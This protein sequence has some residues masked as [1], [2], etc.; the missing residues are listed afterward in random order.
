MHTTV[1]QSL[2]IKLF[3]RRLY[4]L[5][6]FPSWTEGKTSPNSEDR[7]LWTARWGICSTHS[8]VLLYLQH[9]SP[10]QCPMWVTVRLMSRGGWQT[11]GSVLTARLG[12]VRPAT[13]LMEAW[14]ER[15]NTRGETHRGQTP[16]GRQNQGQEVQWDVRMM[17]FRWKYA[18]WVSA[19]WTDILV[20]RVMPYW[21][22][23][24]PQ[25]QQST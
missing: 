6:S 20:K 4:N 18:G 12:E 8:E 14:C 5:I 2:K 13:A 19:N 1:L 16:Q 25:T 3:C 10:S 22:G 9:V 24:K 23:L 21:K 11:H 7:K 17:L 15:L